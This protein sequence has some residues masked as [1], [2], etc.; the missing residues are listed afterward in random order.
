ME[1]DIYFIYILF[2]H[3]IAD[4]I[5]Q[6]PKMRRCK[7][8]SLSVLFDHWLVYTIVLFVLSFPFSVEVD[9]SYMYFLLANSL[10][11][12]FIDLITSRISK[13]FFVRDNMKWTMNIV[14]LDQILHVIIFFIS[15]NYFLY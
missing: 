10:T 13:Y 15:H 8:H 7:S 2:V 3:W 12:F 9:G 5:C 6:T 11:H 1:Y 14:G 4:F